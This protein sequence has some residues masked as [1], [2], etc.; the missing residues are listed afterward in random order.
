MEEV[1]TECRFCGVMVNGPLARG[2]AVSADWCEHGRPTVARCARCGRGLC[3]AAFSCLSGIVDDY[4]AC[5][6]CLPDEI[7]PEVPLDAV[8]L[9]NRNEPHGNTVNLLARLRLQALIIEAKSQPGFPLP[10]ARPLFSS[11]R[12]G[13]AEYQLG[14]WSIPEVVGTWL[15]VEGKP[16]MPKI[17]QFV[18]EKAT[19]VS[20][21]PNGTLGEMG[22]TSDLVCMSLTAESQIN[23]LHAFRHEYLSNSLPKR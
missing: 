4:T 16:V 12:G 17:I 20:A 1:G 8:P 10:I 22:F 5:V 15:S 23:I 9:H 3:S 2:S 11:F 18:T 13:A 7:G 14:C 21:Y 6:T 19:P